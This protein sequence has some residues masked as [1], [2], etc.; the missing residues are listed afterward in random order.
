[1]GNLLT[2]L[3]SVAESMRAVEKSLAVTGNNVTNAGSPGY[4]K[5]RLTLLPRSFELEAGLVGGVEVG[6]LVSARR[7]YLET[8]VQER[9]HRWGRDNQLTLNL[10]RLEPV[11]DI[12]GKSGIGA[13]LDRFFQSLSRW[14]VTP[15]DTPPRQNVIESASALANT[16]QFSAAAIDNIKRDT[17]VETQA[18]ADRINRLGEAI[19]TYNAEVRADVRK[20]EDPGLDAGVHQALEDLAE[21]VDFDLLRQQDGSFTV[22][23]GGQTPLVM[24]DHLYPISVD[25]SSGS[26]A[27][28]D[29]A[30]NDITAQFREGRLYALLDTRNRFLPSLESDLNLLARTV[31]DRVNTV[32]GGGLNRNGN[33]PSA[34]LFTYNSSLGEAATLAV[35]NITPDDLAAASVGAPGGNGNA[36]A[37]ASLA[38]SN[39]INGF[40]FTQFYGGIAGVTGRALKGA[41]EDE[42]TQSQLLSQARNIREADSGVSLDEEAANLIAFQRQYQANAEM[43]RVL[44]S[45][46]ETTVDLLR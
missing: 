5:Q 39:E 17:Q 19:R 9:A 34:N 6:P 13:A 2:S 38:N 1:M 30:G 25:N 45:L 32:L 33:P 3:L 43:L 21:F 46:T 29:A 44:N 40:T 8:A 36:L 27:I 4:V 11:F 16:F 26:T 28:R 22:N 12:S 15:N 18:V 7:D 35:T 24:G 41:R 10:E 37:L 31:A 23:L 14:S 42:Q 20:L